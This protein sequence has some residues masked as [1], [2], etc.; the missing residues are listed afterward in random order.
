MNR[1]VFAGRIDSAPATIDVR[2]LRTPHVV[3]ASG[4]GPII[5]G[6]QGYRY[7]SRF[8]TTKRPISNSYKVQD[9]G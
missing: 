4:Q 5:V 3:D 1:S 9:S 8:S 7:E 2:Y 6:H